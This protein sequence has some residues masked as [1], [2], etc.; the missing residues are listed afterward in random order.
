MRF[1]PLSRHQPSG[2]SPPSFPSSLTLR[3]LP[4][5]VDS[6]IIVFSFLELCNACQGFVLQ[7]LLSSGYNDTPSHL[8]LWRSNLRLGRGIVDF[9]TFILRLSL[10]IRYNAVTSVFLVKNLLNI[11]NTISLIERSRG[12]EGYQKEV[13]FMQYVRPK[14]WY[15]LSQEEWR[16]ATRLTI[17]DQARSGR[18][19]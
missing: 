6:L 18:A 1:P 8:V 16:N 19:V 10:W 9:G 15:G 4:T 14:D 12:V 11:L 5:S 2:P 3:Q 7:V 13:L 17:V